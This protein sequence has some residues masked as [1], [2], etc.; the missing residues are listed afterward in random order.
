[1]SFLI[2]NHR[3]RQP[4]S[5]LAACGQPIIAVFLLIFC[6]ALLASASPPARDHA[7]VGLNRDQISALVTQEIEVASRHWQQY[8]FEVKAAL[9]PG[10][11]TA[12]P[13]QGLDIKPAHP[14]PWWGRLMLKLTCVSPINAAQKGWFG[15]APVEVQVWGPVFITKRPLPRG[16]PV[17]LDDFEAVMQNLVPIFPFPPSLRQLEN[18]VSLPPG[19]VSLSRLQSSTRPP[20]VLSLALM[21]GQVLRSEAIKS[22][23]TVS[24]GDM[25]ALRVRHAQFEMNTSATA[26]MDGGIGDV[27][28][29]KT[30]QG[31]V[32]NATL[33]D[34]KLA[35]VLN[36]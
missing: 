34:Q 21:A 27:I 22:A 33:I 29:V 13:C 32:L 26:L 24:Q 9:L 2:A 15:F 11:S 28:R 31:K 3:Y 1:M 35:E 19:Y 25:V 12:A 8:G 30:E 5:Y 6:P 18:N 10:I 17:N 16:K 4:L 20:Q 36:N 14:Q 7:M 23:P